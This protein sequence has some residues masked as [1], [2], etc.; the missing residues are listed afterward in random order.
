MEIPT[1][2]SILHT[3]SVPTLHLI[4]LFLIALSILFIIEIYKKI[5]NEVKEKNERQ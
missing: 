4:Y 3:V 5:S 1:L 2:S